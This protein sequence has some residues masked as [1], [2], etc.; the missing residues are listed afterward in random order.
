[1][2]AVC[3][4]L[5]SLIFY[6]AS[7]GSE[8][9]FTSGTTPYKRNFSPTLS[10]VGNYKLIL[11]GNNTSISPVLF[12]IRIDDK[13]SVNYRSRINLE[14]YIAPGNFHLEVSL[15]GIKKPNKEFLDVK[16]LT[17]MIIFS[18]DSTSELS[19]TKVALKKSE[20]LGNNSYAFDLGTHQ[21]PL[22]NGFERLTVDSPLLTGKFL[23]AVHRPMGD[24]LLIDGIKGI[25]RL[26]IPVPN[27]NWLVVLWTEDLGEWEYLP[28]DLHRQVKVNGTKLIDLNLNPQEFINQYYLAG[29][30]KNYKPGD[31]AWDLFGTRRGGRVSTSLKVDKQAIIIEMS[32]DG[33]TAQYLAG[34]FIVPLS[35]EHKLNSVI[36]QQQQWY[37]SNWIISSKEYL[38][39]KG[40]EIGYRPLD[41]RYTIGRQNLLPLPKQFV[42]ARDGFVQFDVEIRSSQFDDN[43]LLV[44]TPPQHKL[45]GITLDV[46]ARLGHWRLERP[47]SSGTL[48]LATADHLI[49]DLST[50]SLSPDL[51]VR[52]NLWVDVP[53]KTPPGLYE[54]DIQLSS[55]EETKIIPYRINV[56]P[57]TLPVVDKPVGVYLERLPY[58][59]WFKAQWRIQHEKALECDLLTLRRFGLSSV[60]APIALSNPIDWSDAKTNLNKIKKA[61]YKQPVLSYTLLKELMQIMTVD[62]LVIALK[63]LQADLLSQNVEMPMLAVVDEPH[64][65]SVS[66]LQINQITSKLHSA[67]PNATLLGQLN[68]YDQARL[69]PFFDTVMV[70]TGFGID[71]KN[72]QKI[73]NQN[74]KVWLYNI[75]NSRAAAGFYLWKSQADAYLQWHARMPTADPYDPTDGREADIQLLMP[76]SELCPKVP[77]IHGKLLLIAEG[78]KDYRWLIWLENTSKKRIEANELL[79][80]IQS[81]IPDTTEAVVTLSGES[82]SNWRKKI[83][84]VAHRLLTTN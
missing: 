68:N 83:I 13:K 70:N 75:S 9:N 30:P 61:G 2:K 44:I 65:D 49:G 67:M 32:G 35:K 62:E 38:K 24:D 37:D 60:S 39:P 17:R 48:L 40:L 29:Y 20:T 64:V 8:I 77:D 59:A 51:P 54:G 52:L 5:T 79:F 26:N 28:H 1:M 6:G 41:D 46:D 56:L 58:F 57:M 36:K 43:P 34:I 31:T 76:Q 73:K 55:L 72:I 71:K 10:L 27:G 18:A 11:E 82:M 42:T 81:Q 50:L 14:R 22:M 84:E 12:V 69:L 3:F 25:E 7:F 78:I 47:D 16:N 21:S 80:L 53:A 23:N 74:K 4:L 19:L 63:E 45:K 15:N 66:Y 33:A